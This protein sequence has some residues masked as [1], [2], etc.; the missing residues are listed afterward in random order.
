MAC[1]S[2]TCQS[3]CYRDDTSIGA[4]ESPPVAKKNEPLNDVVNSRRT[5]EHLD[6]SICIKC[7][8]NTTIAAS[9][10]DVFVVD[11]GGSDAGRFCVDCFRSN[12]FGKFR[13]AVTANAMI[14]PSDNVLVAFSGV[15]VLGSEQILIV[16][17]KF[18]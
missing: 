12:L 14:S 17:W 3:G 9:T 18:A 8:V 16:I 10:A 4:A 1:N 2:G 11:G 13:L 6:N 15:L 5:T 7:K